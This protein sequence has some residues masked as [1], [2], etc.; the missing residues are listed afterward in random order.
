MPALINAAEDESNPNRDLVADTLLQLAELLYD[1]LAAPRDY[2]NRRD[3]Q[4][5]R[6]HVL[7]SLEQSVRR[8]QQAPLTK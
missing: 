3:P 4:L 1:E 8:Y 2:R 5:V 6:Q 7:G